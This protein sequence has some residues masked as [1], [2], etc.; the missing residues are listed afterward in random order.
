[1]NKSEGETINITIPRVL[2]NAIKRLAPPQ[3]F[4]L[5]AIEFYLRRRQQPEPEPSDSWAFDLCGIWEDSRP[6]EQIVHDIIS[7]RT[8]GREITL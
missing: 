3:Q 7:A 6:A 4:I 8:P 2:M 1:M 5:E